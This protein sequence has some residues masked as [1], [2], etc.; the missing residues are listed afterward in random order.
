MIIRSLEQVG[1]TQR[2]E[3]ASSDPL[4]RWWRPLYAL[5]LSLI[6]CPAFAS[7]MLHALWAGHEPGINGFGKTDVYGARRVPRPPAR[8]TTG[9][10][11]KST[12][13]ASGS[14]FNTTV[15]P[16]TPFV[17]LSGPQAAAVG[18]G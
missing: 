13:I 7:V 6:E 3:I 16:R 4:Q 14:T 2:A 10:P 1:A 15:I 9:V 8:M 5:E 11:A 17:R 12:W 18:D